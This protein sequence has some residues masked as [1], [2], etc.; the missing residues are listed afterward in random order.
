M[1]R[2]RIFQSSKVA[3]QVNMLKLFNKR[4]KGLSKA[5]KDNAFL[6][7]LSK[8]VLQSSPKPLEKSQK[9]GSICN[10]PSTKI[11]E[12]SRPLASYRIMVKFSIYLLSFL[13]T[14]A[15][16]DTLQKL[17]S[18]LK[19]ASRSVLSSHKIKFITSTG[20]SSSNTAGHSFLHIYYKQPY[21]GFQHPDI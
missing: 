5:I 8:R 17:I 11:N 16:S 14:A 2:L 9:I 7:A 21:Y 18:N 12:N 15:T 10:T 19:S 3:H 4:F 20:D 1:T 6:I 13:N